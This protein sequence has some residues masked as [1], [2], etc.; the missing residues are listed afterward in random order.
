[1]NHE[2]TYTYLDPGRYFLR[3]RGSNSD[4]IWNDEGATLQIVVL[5]PWYKT[6]WFRISIYIS[7]LGIF[8]L[9]YMVRL[10]FFSQQK[11]KLMVLVRERTLQLEEVAV[12]LEEKQE[13]INSQNEKLLTQRN[14][15]ENSNLLLTDQ[16]RQILEQNRELDLHRNQLET[17]IEERTRELIEAK[18]KAEESDRLKS[19]FLANLSHEIRTPLNA[20]LGFSSLLGEKNLASEEREEYNR[21]IHGSSNNLLDLIN[22]ILDISKIEAGQL[23]LDMR[24]VSL[25]AFV[26]DIS[27]VFEMF[28]KRDDVGSNKPVEFKVAINKE[29]RDLHIISDHLRLTQV[30][31]NLI[32]NAIKF[33]SSG[34]IE[35]GC[36]KIP[37]NEFLE[38]YVKDTGIGIKEVYHPLVF[39]RFRKLEDDRHQLHRGT[40]LGL[41]I[42]YQLVNLMGGTMRLDSKYGEGSTFYFTIPLI[43]SGITPVSVKKEARSLLPDMNNCLILVAEDE[44][45]NFNYIEK[46]LKDAGARVLHAENGI[47]VLQIIEDNPGIDLILMDIKMPLMDG[48]ETLNNMRKKGSTIPVIAQ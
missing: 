21:I 25:D 45:S 16:K 35:L 38:F 14:E 12:A 3:I 9:F 8:L 15:L 28:I 2:I 42:S 23:E 20:I 40:G 26:N 37:G 19:S 46:L 48:I 34:Y 27:G 18:N 39:E 13:E 24:E 29:I 6:W 22:D 36:Y 41:A 44:P 17:L 4:G 30:I 32:N 5:P 1:N 31:T 33:T 43:L 7:V 47:Q 10:K 11:R